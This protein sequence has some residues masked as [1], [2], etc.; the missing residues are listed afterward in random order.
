VWCRPSR[1]PARFVGDS[2]YERSGIACCSW[3][4][5]SRFFRSTEAIAAKV[6]QEFAAKDRA[7]KTS[8]PA[9]KTSKK[10]A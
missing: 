8:L 6:K 9:A 4:Q 5:D 1:I 3:K 10:A 7:K 2:V